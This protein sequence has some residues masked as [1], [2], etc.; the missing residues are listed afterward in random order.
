M[1]LFF[2]HT[3]CKDVDSEFATSVASRCC[4]AVGVVTTGVT[5]VTMILWCRCCCCCYYCRDD[6]AWW[7]RNYV[8]SR[9]QS[10]HN[11]CQLYLR[12]EPISVKT[13]VGT[14]RGR[15]VDAPQGGRTVAEYLGIPFARPPLGELRYAD[16]VPL[17][18]LPSGISQLQH[19]LVIFCVKTNA[20]LETTKN[21]KQDCQTW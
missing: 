8:L 4:R 17:D 7:W 14:I 19:Q 16:P 1:A 11:C 10:G 18:T 12:T 5:T 15:I 3:I 6:R 13:S 21:I 9:A 20:R 2:D